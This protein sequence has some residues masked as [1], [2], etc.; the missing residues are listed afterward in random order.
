MLASGPWQAKQ[1]EDKIGRICSLKSIGP[2]TGLRPAVSLASRAAT[3]EALGSCALLD[4]TA[5]PHP[6]SSAKVRQHDAT[7]RPDS[8]D[9]KG[10]L[11][12]RTT[13]NVCFFTLGPPM[14]STPTLRSSHRQAD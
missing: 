12:D 11:L 5:L 8:T 4:A 9:P 7:A 2:V 14:S 3:S 6:P 13:R 1:P 10:R